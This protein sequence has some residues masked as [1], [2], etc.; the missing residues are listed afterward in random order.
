MRQGLRWVTLLALLL[1]QGH[2]LADASFATLT[3][4]RVQGKG[5]RAEVVL[6]GNFETPSYAVRAREEGHVVV[7]EVAGAS[8]S[9]QGVLLEEGT[10]LVRSAVAST[11]AHGVRIELAL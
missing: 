6:D 7:I 8:L 4:V 10:S 3:Q 11:T 1:G 9:Q 5:G 2:A